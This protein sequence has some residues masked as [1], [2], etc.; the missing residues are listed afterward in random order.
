MSDQYKDAIAVLST[1][2]QKEL[3]L[4]K[5]FLSGLGMKLL[6][7]PELDTDVLGTFTGEI[8][9]VD[10][11]ENTLIKKAKMGMELT[12]LPYGIASEG[13]FGPH[14]YLPFMASDYETLVFIDHKNDFVLTEKYLSYKTNFAYCEIREDEDKKLA[15][16]LSQIGFPKHGLIA[17][18]KSPK[19]NKSESL[20]YKGIREINK[21][22]DIIKN[23]AENSLDGIVH[24]ETD[25]RAHM[26]PT[27]RQVIRTLAFRLVKR[28]RN[29]CPACH[30]P[31]WGLIDADLGLDCQ[32]CGAPTE[33][34]QNEIYG[35]VKCA[36]RRKAS[37]KDAL[38][39]AD[40]R[41]CDYCN[42]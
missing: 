39:F 17:K 3:I 28:L 24:L 26:N 36:Y 5:P 40:P 15:D 11:I 42:P 20:I 41:Y 12:G 14:P 33:L 35:C 30:S 19:N 7:P 13:S 31:G 16:F 27:R 18:P 29:Y 22:K 6:V 38:R 10:S 2:H 37:R 4:T 23:C 9:R 1:K 21:L 34:V 8:P 25:M 32:D